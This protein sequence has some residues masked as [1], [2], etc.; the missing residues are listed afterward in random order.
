[1][2]PNEDYV[3]HLLEDAGLVTRTQV[4]K[5]KSKLNG[6]ANV[7]SSGPVFG[8]YLGVRQAITDAEGPMFTGGTSPK[9]ALAAAISKANYVL[10]SYN[11][12]VGG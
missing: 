12:R 3:L 9:A 8:D 5:A 11:S 2:H 10:A 6:A 7:A 4:E 1:M